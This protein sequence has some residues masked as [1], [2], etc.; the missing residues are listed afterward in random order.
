M[1]LTYLTWFK[2]HERFLVIVLA[3]VLVIHLWGSALQAWVNHD[4][5]KASLA[6]EANRQAQSQLEVQTK[7]TLALNA[8]IDDLMRQRAVDTQKQKR[9]DDAAK[10]SEVASR[11]VDL[12]KVKPEE[13]TVSPADNTLVLSNQAAHEDVNALEDLQQSRADVLDLS[14]K[15]GACTA[16]SD[17]KDTALDTEKKSHV[18]DVN[19]EK[20]KVKKAFW[21]GFKFGAI[22]GFIGGVAAHFI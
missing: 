18:A 9:I 13:V 21:K 19:L 22:T 1:L 14:T 11:I 4:K 2:A 10:A 12:L 17:Q 15:L 6:T 7:S 3:A 16:L 5:Q 20:D 8:R